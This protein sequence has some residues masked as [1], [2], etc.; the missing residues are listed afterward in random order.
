M[1]NDIDVSLSRSFFR[2]QSVYD[3]GK[4]IHN[5][6]DSFSI[7]HPS[8]DLGKR[9]KIFNPFDALRGFSGELFKTEMDIMNDFSDNGYEPIEEFP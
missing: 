1:N 7:K 4:P 9:A 8:M 2:Y 6:T 3:K 5:P